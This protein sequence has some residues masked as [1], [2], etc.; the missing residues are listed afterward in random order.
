MILFKDSIM[1]I[2]QAFQRCLPSAISNRDYDRVI[3]LANVGSRASGITCVDESYNKYLSHLTWRNQTTFSHQCQSLAKKAFWWRVLQKVGVKFSPSR[4]DDDERYQGKKIEYITSLLFEVVRMASQFLKDIMIMQSLIADFCTAFDLDHALAVQKHIEYLL[5]IPEKV[6]DDVQI[7]VYGNMDARHNIET[8]CRGVQKLLLSL[9]NTVSR[10]TTLRNCLIAMEKM[11][12]F[13]KDFERYAAVLSLYQKE[14]RDTIHTQT[15]VSSLQRSFFRQDLEAIDRRQDA[16]VIINSI[17]EDKQ[18]DER[19]SVHRCFF[20]LTDSSSKVEKEHPRKMIGVLGERGNYG[21]DA[22]DPLLPLVSC[23]KSNASQSTLSS[24]API[25]FAIGLPSGYIHARALILRITATKQI[26]GSP[27]AFASEVLPVI[28]RLK[29]PRDGAELAEWC[30]SQYDIHSKERLFCLEVGLDLAMKASTQAEQ[31]L[32]ASRQKDSRELIE[33]EKSS[34]ERVERISLA[35]SALSDSITVKSILQN[36]IQ[37]VKDVTL[38]RITSTLVDKVRSYQSQGPEITPEKFA[39]NLLIVGSLICAEACLDTLMPLD[40]FGFYRIASAVHRACKGLEDQYSHIDISRIVGSLVRRYLL[41][42]DEALIQPDEKCYDSFLKREVS[43]TSEYLDMSM[44]EEATMNLVLDLKIPPDRNV[45]GDDLGSEEPQLK[46][47]KTMATTDEGS[48]VNAVTARENSE[49]LSRRVG[50]RVAFIMSFADEFYSYLR[51]D[52]CSNDENMDPNASTASEANLSET[53]AR[54]HAVYLLNIVFSKNSS[55]EKKNYDCS[56]INDETSISIYDRGIHD[57]DNLTPSI[58]SS[59]SSTTLRSKYKEDR[60]ALTFAMRHRALRAACALCPERLLQVIIAEEGYSEDMN[61]R[62]TAERLKSP[63]V[64]MLSKHFFGTFVAKEIEAMGLALPHSDLIQLSAMHHPSYAR[65]LWR[66]HG[67]SSNLGIQGRLMLLILELSLREKKVVDGD[68]VQMILEKVHSL[69]LPRTYLLAC[70]CLAQLPNEEQRRILSHETKIGA[71]WLQLL[72]NITMSIL[73]DISTSMSVKPSHWGSL[74]PDHTLESSILTIQR[75]I[76][77]SQSFWKNAICTMTSNRRNLL[78]LQ[79]L[80]FILSL[81]LDA[82]SECMSNDK[83]LEGINVDDAVPQT[84]TDSLMWELCQ[85][86]LAIFET[87]LQEVMQMEPFITNIQNSCPMTFPKNSSSRHSFNFT[88]NNLQ[89]IL[90]K[91]RTRLEEAEKDTTKTHNWS[92][93]KAET[94]FYQ[95]F[96]IATDVTSRMDESIELS[97]FTKNDQLTESDCLIHL[98]RQDK[99]LYDEMWNRWSS[100][101]LSSLD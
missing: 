59:E 87:S 63:K 54:K 92:F 27:P 72:H 101:P 12:N 15:N 50:L 21:D 64:C 46:R 68:L 78:E 66:N 37:G 96:M 20:P 94:V 99:T 11:D 14:L 90:N 18:L 73:D 4:F 70:E 24:L 2:T 5:S 39:E 38:S 65:T 9:P 58:R 79:P 51:E 8:C 3:A 81:A 43:S 53:L 45:W 76:C 19:P 25:C 85:Y 95:K 52:S 57:R 97:G 22:F 71:L 84:L 40:S 17:F 30:A 91:I 6:N 13:G 89:V 35:K 44:E 86:I 67:K 32:L 60:K 80:L 82:I 75:W 1:K 36:A 16:L 29:S 98:L 28:K 69:N 93:K 62:E 49:Y 61:Q 77:I 34:L 23:L 88:S 83:D 47:V 55:L 74:S 26:G 7:L 31:I 100:S 56:T 41:H 42:G 10:S 33:N 48:S